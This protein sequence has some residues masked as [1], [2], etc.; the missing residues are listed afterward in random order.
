[1]VDYRYEGGDR[2]NG[3]MIGN[4]Q[5]FS[6]TGLNLVFRAGSGTPYSSQSNITNENANIGLQTQGLSRLAGAVNG[7]RLPWQFRV[8][9]R[10]DKDFDL[11]LGNKEKGSQRNVSLNIYILVQNLLDAQNI[12]TVYRATGNADDDGF[13]AS[14]EG[15]QFASAQI[16][17]QS[18]VDMYRI[19]MNRPDYFAL[20]RRARLGAILNF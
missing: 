6:N 20:P 12:V 18:F 5:V 15:Q 3:P 11:K 19:K 2:Y 1:S 4:T 16:D 7:S 17:P 9:A 8:D 14:A 13:L 10:I